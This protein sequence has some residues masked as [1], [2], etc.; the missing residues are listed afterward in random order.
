[1]TLAELLVEVR[2]ALD[3]LDLDNTHWTDTRLTAFLNEGQDDVAMRLPADLV[4]DL[5]TTHTEDLANATQTYSFTQDFVRLDYIITTYSDEDGQ[6][7]TRNTKLKSL[8]WYNTMYDNQ[9]QTPDFEH[10]VALRYGRIIKFFPVPI[11]TEQDG[12]EYYYRRPPVDMG[13]EG[14]EPELPK[15]VHRLLVNYAVY[16]ALFEDGDPRAGDE[17]N[18]YISYFSM[19]G[20]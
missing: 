16:R 18:K 1:M 12:I 6:S 10:P 19:E 15:Q 17:W 8:D 2:Y 20:K 5:L 14:D 3:E 7:Y 13:G 4:P 9:G 11:V